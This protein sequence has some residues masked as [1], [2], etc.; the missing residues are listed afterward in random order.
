MSHSAAHAQQP[1]T[2][3]ATLARQ[4]AYHDAQATS[5]RAADSEVYNFKSSQR[6]LNLS[7]LR[8]QAN[9]NLRA[10]ELEGSAL[11]ACQF[12]AHSHATLESAA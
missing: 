11:A 10:L 2:M 6:H 9:G 8:L 4:L 7:G 1:G 5:R 12:D 3:R